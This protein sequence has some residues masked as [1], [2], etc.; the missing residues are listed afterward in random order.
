MAEERFSFVGRK[1]SYLGGN[2][3]LPPAYVVLVHELRITND[4]MSNS[5]RAVARMARDR[6][7]ASNPE[8]INAILPV[9]SPSRVTRRHN[10]DPYLALVPSP[11]LPGAASTV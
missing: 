5:W 11:I 2:G 9:R 8:E 1:L 7:V 3:P 6:L 10:I 4:Q